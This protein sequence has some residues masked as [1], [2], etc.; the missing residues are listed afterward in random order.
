LLAQESGPFDIELQYQ[1]QVTNT[2][3]ADSGFV[4]P[5][6]SG[7][8]NELT[9]TLVNLDVDV[10]STQAVSIQRD[11]AGSNTVAMLV[12]PPSNDALIGWKPRSRDVK[13]EKP[14]FYAELTQLYAPSAGV[15][16][17]VH[18]VSIRPAQG[19]LNELILDVPRSATITDVVEPNPKAEG[20]N[21]KSSLV[22]LWRFDPDTRKLRVSLNPA[23][24]RPFTLLVRSQVA[25]GPLPFEQSVGLL[26]LDGAAGQIGLLGVATGEEVQLDTVSA[27]TFSPINLEDFPGDVGQNLAAQIAGF[28]VRR[29]FRYNDSKATASLKVSPVAPD[30]RIETQ[31]TLSLGEDRTVLASTLNV[32]ITRAGIFRLSFV[33]PVNFDVEAISG[34]ALSH[35]TEL[36]TDTNR[37]ITLNLQGKTAG[38]QQFV[39][40]LAGP[41]TKATNG[42]TV[43]KLVLREASNKGRC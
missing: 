4:L 31:D 8:I 29:A 23:Q 20:T 24:S 39:I 26:S 3:E 35:W 14:V 13:R 5:T 22:S 41:G 12:L 21:P 16:E 33:S 43:P 38:R 34:A 1:L 32:D 27:D 7:L 15:I 9:L 11:T 6:Q 40:S 30:V 42:W 2:R 28:T 10:F 19:E 36:K 37:V 25:T 18:L 17:G